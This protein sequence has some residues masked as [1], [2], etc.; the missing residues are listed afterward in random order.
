MHPSCKKYIQGSVVLKHS[1]YCPQLC[2]SELQI[3]VPLKNAIKAR[4]F[5]S[6]AEEQQVRESRVLQERHII[7]ADSFRSRLSACFDLL[8]KTTSFTRR[9]VNAIPVADSCN[10]ADSE[11]VTYVRSSRVSFLRQSSLCFRLVQF[12]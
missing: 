6:D 12:V 7:F 9:F 3:V 10:I 8:I 1:L 2:F 4:K 11:N 5:S